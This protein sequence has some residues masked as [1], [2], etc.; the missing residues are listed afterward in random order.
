MTPVSPLPPRHGLDAVRLRTPDDGPWATMRDH[1]VARL[2][3]S[4]PDGSTPCWPRA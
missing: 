1:L 2:P 3:A 4:R